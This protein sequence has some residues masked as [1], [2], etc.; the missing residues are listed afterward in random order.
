MLFQF[1]TLFFL[2]RRYRVR[3]IAMSLSVCL[4]YVCPFAYLK[5]HC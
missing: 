2:R 1:F 4:Y 3:S 5:K